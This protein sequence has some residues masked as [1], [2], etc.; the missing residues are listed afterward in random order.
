[1]IDPSLYKS[2]KP[3]QR[4]NFFVCVMRLLRET[5]GKPCLG[6]SP[7]GVD[8]HFA[9]VEVLCAPRLFCFNV[10]SFRWYKGAASQTDKWQTTETVRLGN[11]LSLLP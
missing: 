9:P 4:Y 11:S 7:P 8:S 1:M 3:S 10:E 5:Q 6:A 2:I